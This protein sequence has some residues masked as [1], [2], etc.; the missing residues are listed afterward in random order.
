MA[1]GAVGYEEEE[2]EEDEDAA[3]DGAVISWTAGAGCP[4]PNW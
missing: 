3:A 1:C 4:A 2:E